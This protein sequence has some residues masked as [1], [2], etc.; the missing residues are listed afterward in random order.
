MRWSAVEH[1]LL[2]IAVPPPD[3]QSQAA[4]IASS[5]ERLRE[6][7][8]TIGRTMH[9]VWAAAARGVGLG[10]SDLSALSHLSS[11]G[12][13]T[14]AELGQVLGLSS[15]SITELADRLEDAGLISRSRSK[16]DRR[17]TLLTARKA[18]API[19]ARLDHIACAQ[20]P[21]QLHRSVQLLLDI[22]AALSTPA[23]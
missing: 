16:N 18:L 7:V 14:G 11:A 13:M 20:A 5:P 19:D 2:L 10:S 23:R 12:A 9:S 22:S 6:L 1:G 3:P 4:Q 17:H 8:Q 21:T 15:S